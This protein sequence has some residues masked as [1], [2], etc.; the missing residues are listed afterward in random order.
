MRKRRACDACHSRKIRCDQALPQCDWCF[1][2]N[3]SCTFQQLARSGSEAVSRTQSPNPPLRAAVAGAVHSPPRDQPLAHSLPRLVFGKLH[4]AGR[5]LGS[6]SFY[7]GLPIFS[8]QGR[9]WIRSRSGQDA[10]L[11]PLPDHSFI[12]APQ[13]GV[14]LSLPC[15]AVVEDYL[16]FFRRSHLKLEFPIIDSPTFHTTIQAAYGLGSG[17]LPDPEAIIAKA[18]VLAFLSVISILEGEHRPAAMQVDSHKCALKAHHLLLS[19]PQTPCITT[20][21][22]TLMLSIHQ[23]FSGQIPLCAVYHSVACRLVFMMGGHV[24]AD[25][26]TAPNQTVGTA[27]WTAQEKRHLRKLFWLCY[28]FDKEISSRTGQPPS[29]SDDHCDLTLPG[30]YL[31]VQY[32]DEYLSADVAHL[33][34]SAAPILPGD[35]RLIMIKSKA[36]RLL[37]SAEALRKSDAD[38]LRDIRE[39]DEELEEWRLSVPPKHRPVLSLSRD[40]WMEGDAPKSIRTVMIGFEYHHL[41]ATIHKATSRC[42]AWTARETRTCEMDSVKSSLALAVEASRSSLLTLRT[43]V[44]GLL[45]KASWTIVFYPMS[46]VVTIFCNLLWDPLHP[47][48]QDDLDL[49]DA[50]PDLMRCI[51]RQ[52]MTESE[53]VHQRV[54]DNLLAELACLGR[55]AVVRARQEGHVW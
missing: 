9:E 51:R 35:L 37:Y 50:A 12:P 32:M 46:A 43:A 27:D 28:I 30:G 52:G 19:V 42:M 33:D 34:E 39:L 26:W 6:I 21:Q 23:L 13:S 44:H 38:L 20:L 7:N 49:L 25:P 8:D 17:P 54:A 40:R 53:I 31:E 24:I 10:V 2:H 29:V 16:S 22:A 11:P 4:F 18:C 14:D 36:C 55:H 1:H 3:A 45:E 48:A 47:R 15:R 41:M 5:D